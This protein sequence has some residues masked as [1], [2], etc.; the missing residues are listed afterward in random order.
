MVMSCKVNNLHNTA[1]DTSAILKSIL[2]LKQIDNHLVPGNIDSI[3][4]IKNKYYNQ[5][6]PLRSG[7]FII[8]YLNDSKIARQEN[9]LNKDSLDKRIR[10]IAPTFNISN[11]SS[12]VVLY[13]LNFGS[14]IKCRLKNHSGDWRVVDVVKGMD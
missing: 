1:K 12:V 14:S 3:Y 2:A 6:W 9:P 13:N 8:S 11:D 4:M 10:L 7:R 5:G